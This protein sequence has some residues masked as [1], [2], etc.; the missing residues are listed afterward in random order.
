[1]PV[2][3]VMNA[4][5]VLKAPGRREV[6]ENMLLITVSLIL[7]KKKKRNSKR[8]HLQDDIIGKGHRVSNRWFLLH[9]YIAYVVCFFFSA[10][11]PWHQEKKTSPEQWT[12]NTSRQLPV[13]RV[14]RSGV[15]RSRVGVGGVSGDPHV[16]QLLWS[17]G[18]GF[19]ERRPWCFTNTLPSSS[20]T[21]YTFCC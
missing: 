20:F 6:L 11:S 21:S 2:A 19:R 3:S 17:V 5:C 1:M 16:L 14:C 7:G 10:A 18:K 4:L 9:F 8:E 15:F 13:G 12:I